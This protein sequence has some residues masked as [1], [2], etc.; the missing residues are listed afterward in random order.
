MAYTFNADVNTPEQIAMSLN[1]VVEAAVAYIA[2]VDATGDATATRAALVA[3]INA[4][5]SPNVT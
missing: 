2:V 4:A 5:V 3:A 1:N